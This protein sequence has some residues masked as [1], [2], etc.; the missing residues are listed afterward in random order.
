MELMH[1]VPPQVPSPY[2]QWIQNVMKETQA[3][4]LER[5]AKYCN[6]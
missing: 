5:K 1:A 3:E 6:R 4:R 2:T